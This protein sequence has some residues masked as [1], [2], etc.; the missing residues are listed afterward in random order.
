MA[1]AARRG[2]DG[3]N[4]GLR[5]APS[6]RARG[7]RDDAMTGSGGATPDLDGDAL[8][9]RGSDRDLGGGGIIPGRLPPPRRRA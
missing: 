6:A 3:A 7:R 9:Y 4:R 1:L 2:R 5:P 8:G